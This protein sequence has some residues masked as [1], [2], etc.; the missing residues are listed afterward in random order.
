MEQVERVGGF[1]PP[2]RRSSRSIS[3]RLLFSVRPFRIRLSPG[4]LE[5][6]R[7]D[8]LTLRRSEDA[9]VDELF[10]PCVAIGAPLL[11]ALFH[12]LI[13]IVPASPTNSIRKFSRVA[14]PIR[15]HSLAQGSRRARDDSQGR[16]RR[17]AH[18]QE[19]D[20]GRGG[21]PSDRDALPA[22][23]R[24]IESSDRAARGWFGVAVLLDCHRCP[25]TRRMSA[26][27]YRAWRPLGASAAPGVV[28]ILET[29][30]K[31]AGYVVRRNKPFA[32]DLLRNTS[33]FPQTASMRSRSRSLDRFIL[34]SERL[35]GPNGGLRY[36]KTYRRRE[37]AGARVWRRSASGPLGGR[38]RGPKEGRQR[39]AQQPADALHKFKSAGTQQ[40]RRPPCCHGGPEFRE[41]TPKEGICGRSCRTATIS[42]VT[43]LVASPF[44]VQWQVAH[45]FRAA[46]T[47]RSGLL[48]TPKVQIMSFAAMV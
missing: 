45:W 1:D 22:L 44:F 6:S 10:L 5:A 30:L 11:R 35:S 16:G 25:R 39:P 42:S 46:V 12:G 27:R 36:R 32:G 38:M 9:F 17:R 20:S 41:E 3:L 43:A 14:F 26:D 40:K 7:L 33:A 13:S 34:M 29:N 8:P 4:F 2:F 21:S 48:M 24:A 23:P 28:D 37:S 15:K 31:S 47:F 19:A 18:L